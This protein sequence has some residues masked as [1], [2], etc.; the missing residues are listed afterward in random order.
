MEHRAKSNSKPSRTVVEGPFGISETVMDTVR[1]TDPP[2]SSGLIFEHRCVGI[3]KLV[4][5]ARDYGVSALFTGHIHENYVR[6]LAD[7]ALYVINAGSATL[8]K[9]STYNVYTFRDNQLVV[10]RREFST[11]IDG[12]RTFD[13]QTLEL[14]V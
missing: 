11:E 9:H 14:S 13:T 12:F 8:K 7:S 6:R 2:R 4:N 1:I 5:V 3:D 10:D